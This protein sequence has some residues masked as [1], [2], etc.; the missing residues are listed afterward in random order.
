MAKAKTEGAVTDAEL[1]G[2]SDEEREALEDEDTTDAGALKQL[3][4]EGEEDEGA[5]KPKKKDEKKTDKAED[6]DEDTDDAE[7]GNA[8]EEGAKGKEGAKAD[9]KGE[10][11]AGDKDA[12]AAADAETEDEEAD[13][14]EPQPFFPRYSAPAVEKYEEK[15]TALDTRQ[16]EAEAK[17]KAG[18]LELDGLLAEQRKIEG[19]RRTLNEAKLKYDISVEQNAQSDAQSWQFE[20]TRFMHGVKQAD[21]VDYKANRTLNAA[22]D[23]A[24]KDLANA[25]DKDG[26]LVNDDKPGRWFLRE[27]HKQ[28]MKDIGRGKAGAAGG[29]AAETPEEKKAKAKAA[30]DAR[31][32]DP[33]K[34]PKTLA[35]VPAADAEDTEGDPKFAHLEGLDGLD[36]EDAVARMTPAQQDEWARSSGAV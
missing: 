4:E 16:T 15:I 13:D 27:A 28:V 21:G 18:D 36:L 12:G 35:K 19:D 23:Q 7:E 6:A 22:L 14:D 1:A 3:A 8:E 5:E 32:T 17:F 29:D 20:I 2:L 11:K 9:D 26:K 24:V 30:V 31:K 25:K 10:K 34:L 33:K